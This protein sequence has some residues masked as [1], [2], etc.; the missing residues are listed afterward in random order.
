VF[1]SIKPISTE[2][3]LNPQEYKK[4]PPAR[5]SSSSCSTPSSRHPPVTSSCSPPLK[6]PLLFILLAAGQAPPSS[7]LLPDAPSAS[8]SLMSSAPCRPPDPSSPSPCRLHRRVF[9]LLFHSRGV[10]GTYSDVN[11][12]LH[13]R[14]RRH[15]RR[16][17]GVPDSQIRGSLRHLIIARATPHGRLKN[18]AHEQRAASL[19]LS[20][21]SMTFLSTVHHGRN[22]S[23]T[24]TLSSP[25]CR[26][27][28]SSSSDQSALLA[29]AS[30]LT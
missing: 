13:G 4:S 24:S 9:P 2:Y 21:R 16:T 17:D 15:I 23:A 8:S 28:R 18:Y 6:R 7:F 12:T 1:Q 5:L 19:S 3:A 14:T 30:W 25:S 22:T 26:N 10:H 27:T 29:S 20:V 11:R